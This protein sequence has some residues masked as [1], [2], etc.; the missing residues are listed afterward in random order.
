VLN[1]DVALV[2]GGTGDIGRG[3]C[4]ALTKAGATVVAVDLNAT[5]AEGVARVIECDVTDAIACQSAVREAVT[6]FGEVGTLVNLAQQW[7]RQPLV[8]STDDDW[9][10]AYASG[11]LATCR[12]MQLCYPHMKA[13]GG[14]AIVNCGSTAGTTGGAGG[15]AYAAAKEAIRGLTKG[16]AVEWAPDNISVNVICPLATHDPDRWNAHGN[17][18]EGVPM[19]RLGDPETDVGAL[20]VFLA[21]PGRF[22]TG[23]TLFVDGGS[24]TFR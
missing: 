4:R 7:T 9:N 1:G 23:R 14:G 11:P 5:R 10:L 12:M 22:V 17:V 24:G 18:A 16:A 3:V 13:R 20:V 15:V 2:T 8:D 21:G 19:G 6:D